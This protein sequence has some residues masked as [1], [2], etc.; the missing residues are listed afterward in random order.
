[1]T[2][3]D[4]NKKRVY[5]AE[6]STRILCAKAGGRGS[7]L[8]AGDV[9]FTDIGEAQHFLDKLARPKFETAAQRK[10]DPINLFALPKKGGKKNRI[11]VYFSQGHKA[12]PVDAPA[13]GLKPG[14]GMTALVL[15]HEYA[16]HLAHPMESI[17]PPHGSEYA[18]MY[19]DT[20]ERVYTGEGLNGEVPAELRVQYDKHAV[21]YEPGTQRD[22]ARRQMLRLRSDVL[23]EDESARIIPILC[24][25]YAKDP[26]DF[27]GDSYRTVETNLSLASTYTDELVFGRGKSAVRISPQQLRYFDAPMVRVR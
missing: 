21:I 23:L 11:G 6:Q 17:I 18:R 25:V 15:L 26:H 7:H 16:H 13:I 14:Q 3:R 10:A 20:V 19:L 22:A 24:V 9:T 4:T 1:M 8:S 5:D 2:I 12:L 27:S